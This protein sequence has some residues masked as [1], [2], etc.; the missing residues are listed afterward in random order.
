MEIMERME[1]MDRHELVEGLIKGKITKEAAE[2]LG[3]AF[4]IAK[5]TND[6][7]QNQIRIDIEVIKRTMATKADLA[8]LRT[9]L[10]GDIAEIKRDIKWG[11]ALLIGISTLC[12]STLGILLKIA[13]TH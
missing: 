10:K 13:F 3:T 7:E 9:E 11:M 2:L 4:V 1:I 12:L 8:E 6:K 5:E